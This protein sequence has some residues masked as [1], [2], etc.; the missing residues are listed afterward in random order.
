MHRYGED[1]LSQIDQLSALSFNSAGMRGDEASALAMEVELLRMENH[2][3]E[4]ELQAAHL[5]SAA[6]TRELE[7]RCVA[8][9]QRASSLEASREADQ[10]R[11]EAELARGSEKHAHEMV[12][13]LRSRKHEIERDEELLRQKAAALRASFVPLE[14]STERYAELKGHRVDT[15]PFKEW[16]QLQVHE[17]VAEAAQQLEL[18][19]RE[20]DELELALAAS[21]ETEARAQREAQQLSQT[22]SARE[23]AIAETAVDM[24]EQ[25]GSLRRE[26]AATTARYH[27][28]SDDAA[29]YDATKA[30]ARDLAARVDVLTR[31]RDDAAAKYEAL[32][33]TASNSSAVQQQLDLVQQDKM[34]LTREL[35]ALKQRLHRAEEA[36]DAAKPQLEELKEQKQQL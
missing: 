13:T 2:R 18:A 26:M 19:R 31:E 8:A 35:E 17:R 23:A 14:L 4:N 10:H 34:Y 12:D 9:E 5:Q 29:T 11:H 7:A 27:Q 6:K 1:E 3:L 32:A 28:V 24:E 22:L 25:L 15:L 21:R 30:K 16:L 33:E 36:A 20:R